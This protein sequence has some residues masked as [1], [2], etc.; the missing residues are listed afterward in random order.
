MI[1]HKPSEKA[2][3]LRGQHDG[4]RGLPVNKFY[5]SERER[6][7]YQRGYGFGYNLRYRREYGLIEF[8]RH[9]NRHPLVQ[10]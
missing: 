3:F 2:I 9:G 10:N 4:E 7:L 8:K 1:Y 6:E 5:Y